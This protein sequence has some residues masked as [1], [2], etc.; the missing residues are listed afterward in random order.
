[1]RMKKRDLFKTVLMLIVSA[2]FLMSAYSIL[3]SNKVQIEL[4]ENLNLIN[5]RVALGFINI[6]IVLSLWIKRT[7]YIGISVGTA[8][9]GAAIASELFMGDAGLI[10]GLTLIMIWVI[11]RIDSSK[12][13]NNKKSE[14]RSYE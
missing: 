13:S 5:Y 12:I 9:L 3:S 6:V 14:L 1:M 4:L 8:Y 7:R 2:L 10:P 11:Q